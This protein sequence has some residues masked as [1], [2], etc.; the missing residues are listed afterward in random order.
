[1]VRAGGEGALIGELDDLG[2]MND[3]DGVTDMLDDHEVVG[4]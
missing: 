4:D 2:G 3:G 1:V